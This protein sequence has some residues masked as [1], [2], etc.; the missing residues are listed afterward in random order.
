L[1]LLYAQAGLLD[2]AEQ[3]LRTLRQ[4]NPD[5]EAVRRWL[6]QVQARRR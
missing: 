5:S 1:G 2:E 6:A 4:A 3:E